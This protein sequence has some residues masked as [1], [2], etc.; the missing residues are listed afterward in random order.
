MQRRSLQGNGESVRRNVSLRGSLTNRREWRRSARCDPTMLQRQ[1][2]YLKLPGLRGDTGAVRRF[3]TGRYPQTHQSRAT[4]PD[5]F[6]P[7]PA[8]LD[9]TERR[10]QRW[11]VTRNGPIET[12]FDDH[13]KN[14]ADLEIDAL[15]QPDVYHPDIRRAHR[16]W[17]W[18]R[19]RSHA[20]R[21][22]GQ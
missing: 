19:R 2:R 7:L 21:S 11:I 5:R 6:E 16:S 17:L 20:A 8:L 13:F 4:G 9:R 12:W 10:Y 3:L 22:T 18:R 14:V 1:N 15:I